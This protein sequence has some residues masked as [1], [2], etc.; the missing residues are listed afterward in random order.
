M[1]FNAAPQGEVGQ[2]Q[3]MIDKL[4]EKRE[5]LENKRRDLE[6]SI[7]NM[8]RYAEKCRERLV[9]LENAGREAVE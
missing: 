3:T 5:M 1:I 7:S 2:L 6:A 8:D 4:D 9:A